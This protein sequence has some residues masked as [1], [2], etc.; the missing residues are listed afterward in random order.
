MNIPNI[1]T[2][3]RL[4]LIPA[5]L[6]V[7]FSELPNSM[8][9]SFLIFIFAGITDFL[10]GYIARKYKLVTKWGSIADPFA[11]KL[12]SITV[13]LSLTID[14]IIPIWVPIVI[15]A[16]ELL[17]IIGGIV[18]YKKGTYVPAKFYG[19]AATALFYVAV[20]FLVINKIAGIAIMRTFGLIFIYITVIVTLYAFYKYYENFRKFTEGKRQ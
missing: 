12:M 11:D 1:L 13:L 8:L 15:V 2:I 19:K 18:L 14:E 5:F 17:M 20:L 6:F 3:I 4:L 9:L 10:D 16:K 7:F